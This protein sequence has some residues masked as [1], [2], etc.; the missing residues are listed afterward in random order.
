M[1]KPKDKSFAIPK[2][3]VWEAWRQV[4]AN[5]GAPGVDG[6][7][8]EEFEA[9]LRDN[10]YVI[11]NRMSSGSYFPLPVR[12]VEVLKPHG[13]GV[14][15][16]GVPTIADRV[17]QSVV[18]M[19][20]GGRAEPWFHRDSYGYRPGKSALQAVGVCRRRC[21]KFDWIIDLDVQ[22]FFDEVPWDL[23]VKAVQ[24][25]TDCRWVLLYV[26]RW[27]RAPL[28]QPDGTLVERD[29]GTPQGSRFRR[30]WRTC[31]CISRSMRGWSG[32]TRIVRLSA[33][34]TMVS[35]IAEAGGRQRLCLPGSLR[36]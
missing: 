12:A 31:S 32:I 17:A 7:D 16:L 15:T 21:W 33:T 1:P 24:A 4:K 2:S 6:Q 19:Y 26:K 34:P 14:R 18:A 13:G 20:L 8:L 28:Q 29:K 5:K 27:L 22:K 30:S 9:D 3:M 35:C 25:I 36:G 10:L 23:V 11:W